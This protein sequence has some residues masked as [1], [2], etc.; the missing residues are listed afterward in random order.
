M[1]SKVAYDND[2]N[3]KATELRLG[4][5]GTDDREEQA[6]FSARNNKRPLPELNEKCGSKGSSDAAHAG[7]ETAPPT[8][9]VLITRFC[10]CISFIN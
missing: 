4:L 5:P 1:E 3:L 7:N 10:P 8:K 6:L 2:L 9:L